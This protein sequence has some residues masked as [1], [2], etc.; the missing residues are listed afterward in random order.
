MRGIG[1]LKM[2]WLNSQREGQIP[3]LV[4]WQQLT[5][6]RLTA[7]VQTPLVPIVKTERE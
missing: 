2:S 4:K 1:R 5:G 7:P 6:L 3:L